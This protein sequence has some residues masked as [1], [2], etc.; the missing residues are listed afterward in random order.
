MKKTLAVVGMLSVLAAAPAFARDDADS[1]TTTTTTTNK[2]IPVHHKDWNTGAFADHLIKKMDTDG[3]GKISA[4]EHAAFAE[5]MFQEADTNHDG[6]LTRD[7]LIAY[8]QQKHAQW[9]GKTHHG[10]G[11]KGSASD[12]NNT[13]PTDANLHPTKDRQ[14]QDY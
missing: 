3:D 2:T 1:S 4:D 12:T 13:T 6:Y 9:A 10:V 7:E 8:H 14:D 5:K 11:H